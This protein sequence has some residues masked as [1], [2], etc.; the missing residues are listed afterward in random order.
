MA[1]EATGKSPTFTDSR[2]MSPK[3]EHP[4]T[5]VDVGGFIHIWDHLA[6]V[7]IFGGWDC[8]WIIGLVENGNLQETIVLYTK[9]Q[10]FPQIFHSSVFGLE[11]FKNNANVWISRGPPFLNKT[12]S[13]HI[14]LWNA[15][16]SGQ[17]SRLC[18]HSWLWKLC[19][20]LFSAPCQ[21]NM[22]PK[23]GSLIQFPLEKPHSKT[24]FPRFR[25]EF[26]RGST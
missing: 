13:S 10:W 21:F 24:Q 16:T 14:P 20:I 11:S 8:S 6:N 18:P 9:M 2:I 25:V 15:S 1:M 5:I 12:T 7:L 22:T 23:T 4:G 3:F 26:W 17:G 19:C